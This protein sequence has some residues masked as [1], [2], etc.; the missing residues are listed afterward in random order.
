MCGPR[1]HAHIRPQFFTE[2]PN[3][4]SKRPNAI[5]HGPEIAKH[6]HKAPTLLGLMRSGTEFHGESEWR[7]PNPEFRQEK[8]PKW[9]L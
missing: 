9:I 2:N 5:Q 8:G 3:P 1:G 6:L 4:G 7:L